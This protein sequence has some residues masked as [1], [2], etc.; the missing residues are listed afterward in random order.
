MDEKCCNRKNLILISSLVVTVLLVLDVICQ[1]EVYKRLP[2][3]WQNKL[4]ECI[5]RT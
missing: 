5:G 2:T 4:S 1:G 3:S